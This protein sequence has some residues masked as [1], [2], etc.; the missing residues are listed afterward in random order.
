MEQ[1][2]KQ[3]DDLTSLLDHEQQLHLQTDKENRE[4]KNKISDLNGYLVNKDED[5]KEDINSKNDDKK[6]IFSKLF[7]KNK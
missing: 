4:L 3:I 6:S 1:K 5:E 7:K 2:D